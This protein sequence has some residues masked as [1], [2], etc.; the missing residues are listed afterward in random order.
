MIKYLIFILAI[1]LFVTISKCY[2]CKEN[3]KN[4]KNKRSTNSSNICQYAED[5][6][7]KLNMRVQKLELMLYQLK[8][9]K[10]SEKRLNNLQKKCDP[11]YDWYQSKKN[12]SKQ[13]SEKMLSEL[14]F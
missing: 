7:Q 3:F 9:D 8:K 14:G 10:K 6:V 11:A 13:K 12:E 1:L 4:N 5:Q 2:S